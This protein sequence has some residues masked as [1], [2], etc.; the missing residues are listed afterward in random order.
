MS[1]DFAGDNSIIPSDQAVSVSCPG[2]LS[3]EQL[4]DLLFQTA[5][6]ELYNRN[7]E[8]F[9]DVMEQIGINNLDAQDIN[10]TMVSFILLCFEWRDENIP[11]DK[12]L[13]ISDAI[14]QGVERRNKNEITLVEA[15]FEVFDYKNPVVDI[16]PSVTT[17]FT[18]SD[19]M[20]TDEIYRFV[21]RSTLGMNYGSHI[22]NLMNY[23]MEPGTEHA[24]QKLEIAYGSQPT[25]FYDTLIDKIDEIHYEKG[26]FNNIIYEY[27]VEKVRQGSKFAPIPKD[28]IHS[29][30]LPDNLELE[31]LADSI[32]APQLIT[33]SVEKATNMIM[34][35][36]NTRSAVQYSDRA[37]TFQVITSELEKLPKEEYKIFMKRYIDIISQSSLQ[38]DE[39]LFKIYGPSFP[40]EGFSMLDANGV[41]V[42]DKYG[43]CRMLLCEG[44]TPRTDIDDFE[45]AMYKD[46]FTG[47]CCYCLEKIKDRHLARRMPL[48]NGGWDTDC[49]CSWKCVSRDIMEPDVIQ[50]LLVKYFRKK[51]RKIGIFDRVY[52]EK[53]DDEEEIEFAPGYIE[54]LAGFPIQNM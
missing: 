20:L 30:I 8:G 3:D 42:C 2:N 12:I 41:S 48:P 32:L 1:D 28:I 7:V 44:H 50:N 5:T 15:I 11:T 23:G 31:K 9:L 49:Y 25:R 21:A 4:V 14:S 22:Y 40:V 18:I 51:C 19:P 37:N 13:Q 26:S 39:T 16:R 34:D 6:N 27:A 38:T 17:F 54:K 24:L 53:P 10:E 46:W 52:I 45:E 35:D 43:G 29:D 33:P 36:L 47:S